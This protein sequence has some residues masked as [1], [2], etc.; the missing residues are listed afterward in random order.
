LEQK[1][2]QAVNGALLRSVR[3]RRPRYTEIDWHST[4]RHNLRHYQPSYQTIIA[5]TLIGFGRKNRRAMKDIV[6]CIDQSGSMGT[7]IVYSGIFAAVLASIP[8]IRTRL[9]AFDTAVTDLSEQL[10]D[11]VDLLFGIQLGGGT[12]IAKAL[13]YARTQVLRPEDTVLIL[14]TDLFEGG[15]VRDM[16]RHLHELQQVGVQIICL[17]T[18]SDDGTPSFDRENAQW[19]ST[20]NIPSFACTPDLFPEFMGAALS[21]KDLPLWAAEHGVVVK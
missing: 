15:N 1:T 17:L 2:V 9:I 12:D 21:G 10:S 4:I 14:I 19:L 8:T 20:L 11:P 16:R 7:S 5:E 3:R 18:L 13:Q 6:M